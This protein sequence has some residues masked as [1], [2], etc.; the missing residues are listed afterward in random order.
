[1]NNKELEKIRLRV[2][3]RDFV[4]GVIAIGSGVLFISIC[5]WFVNFLYNFI[6]FGG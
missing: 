5:Q 4:R 3:K 6:T 2:L 1:M